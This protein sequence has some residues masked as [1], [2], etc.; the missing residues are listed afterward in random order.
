MWLLVSRGEYGCVEVM[1]GAVVTVT[2]CLMMKCRYTF[3][4]HR[5]T[6]GEDES[7]VEMLTDVN[8]VQYD[9]LIS[10]LNAYVPSF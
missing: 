4:I 3:G 8:L 1:R 9:S 10:Y 7:S 6:C 2:E 5:E